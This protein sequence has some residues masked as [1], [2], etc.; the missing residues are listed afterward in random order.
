MRFG[1]V[2]MIG[3]LE[4][5]TIFFPFMIEYLVAMELLHDRL[6]S[7]WT[8]VLKFGSHRNAVSDI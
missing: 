6:I 5:E 8:W 1:L 4:S 3:Q 2:R 7:P